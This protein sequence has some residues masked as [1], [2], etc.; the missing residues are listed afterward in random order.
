M[1]DIVGHER[2][3]IRTVDCNLARIRHQLGNDHS[4]RTGIGVVIRI[5]DRVLDHLRTE[6]TGIWRIGDKCIVEL[7]RTMTGRP[8]RDNTRLHTQIVDDI[9]ARAVQKC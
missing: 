4:D 3:V 9:T 7:H 2:P 8:Y 6:K 1:Q 5:R